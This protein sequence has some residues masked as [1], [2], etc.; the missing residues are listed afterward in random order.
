MTES[1]RTETTLA[2]ELRAEEELSRRRFVHANRL[3]RPM[4]A[5]EAIALHL[6]MEGNSVREPS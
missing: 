1:A 5:D 3:K 4:S 2:E 6:R